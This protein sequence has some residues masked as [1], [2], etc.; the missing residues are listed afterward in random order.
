[1]SGPGGIE[2]GRVRI[3]ALPD[4]EGFADALRADLERIE[5]EVVV[6][7]PTALDLTG[8]RDD[9]DLLQ[10][11]INL[12]DATV[13][14]DLDTGAAA[15]ELDEIARDRRSHVAVEVDKASLT[16]VTGVL[17][18]L[19][20]SLAALNPT[21]MAA[22]SSGLA[23][24]AYSAGNLA[25]ALVPAAG[26]IG[27]LPAAGFAGAA[28]IATLTIGLQGF[29]AAAKAVA[30]GD[31]KKLAEAMKGLAPAAQDTVRQLQSM[32]PAFRD[33]K[34]G[35]QQSLFTDVATNLKE[36][37]GTFLPILK[38][39][40]SGIAS[41]ISA[42]FTATAG[43][44]LEPATV[45]YIQTA[46]GNVR[47]AFGELVDIGYNLTGAFAALTAVGSDFLP[48]LAGGL[49]EAIESFSTFITEAAKTGQL[50]GWISAGLSAIG[51]LANIASAA[52][53][54]IWGIVS[55]AQSVGGGSLAGIL[56][57][58]RG[59]SGVINSAQGQQALGTIFAGV[60]AGVA[61]LGGAFGPLGNVLAA[62]APTI[63]TI[64]TQL[65][66]VLAAAVQAIA[67]TLVTLAPALTDI[68]EILGQALVRALQV[69]GPLLQRLAAALASNRPLLVAVGVAI[70]ALTGPMG[71][72][73]AA[74]A[75]VIVLWQQWGP[76]ITDLAQRISG[77]LQPVFAAFAAAAQSLWPAL[78]GLGSAMAGW[79]STVLP[80][81]QQV[82]Q[83]FIDQWPAIQTTVAS[84]FG[85]VVSIIRS[86][87]TIIT[88]VIRAATAVISALWDSGF[89]QVIVSIVRGAF[90]QVL[91]VIRTTWSVISG[92]FRTVAAILTGDW[93]GAWQAIKDTVS[94]AIGGMITGLRNMVSTVGGI[95][96][97]LGQLALDAV[98]G[99]GTLL[100]DA[101]KA[102]IQGLIDGIGS[103]VGNVGDAIGGVAHKIK[104]FFGGSP[105]EEGPLLSWNNGGA[106]KRLVRM[107]AD[108]LSDTR[109]VEEAARHIASTVATTVTP[110]LGGARMSLTS[111]GTVPSA[112]G[113]Q[114]NFTGPIY[115]RD[116]DA[117]VR[118]ASARAARAMTLAGVGL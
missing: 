6:E 98:K 50:E 101:G 78:Q 24:A 28:G 49:N 96:K 47:E 37:G 14:V 34:T 7:L 48:D 36:L 99:F 86:A 20:G 84:V 22:L 111:T 87:L 80:I 118:D 57:V 83:V 108:G 64:A 82:A 63:G 91:N 90:S 62:L 42:G 33:L 15:A 116:D 25:A 59:L 55:A 105:V 93:S 27:L 45:A 31:T 12:T 102:L 70:A 5:H 94:S 77:G 107:L 112:A 56:S 95:F 40:L 21:K 103:M 18:K 109:A 75:G 19:N 10:E 54:A 65:G 58:V 16:R 51:D 72:V 41:T 68:A 2:A 26:A 114:V 97:G 89:G 88:Q 67:P 61:Q 39:Q 3:R 32:V 85:S 106:G 43:S 66:G 53:Q 35:I 74:V 115:A 79:A 9:L 8:A 73:A 4:T 52:A 23:A 113:M 46:L 92:L 30:E 71:L 81:V 44:L 117:V 100:I 76:Q 29:G 1:M 69:A 13:T 38:T 110:A 11:E 60:A 17:G 104:G